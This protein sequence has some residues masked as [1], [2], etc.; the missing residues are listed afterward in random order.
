VEVCNCYFLNSGDESIRFDTS[1]SNNLNNIRIL[2]CQ[3]NGENSTNAAYGI[4]IGLTT[5]ANGIINVQ[6]IGNQV[7]NWHGSGIAVGPGSGSDSS[8]II[9]GNVINNN[10]TGNF[11]AEAGI[12]L[13]T[14]VGVLI[15]GNYLENNQAFGIYL[16]SGDS[17][18]TIVGNDFFNNPVAFGTT[19]S[20]TGV[21][22][23]NNGVD[24]VIVSIPSATNLTV[25]I[26]PNFVITGNTPIT[27]LIGSNLV[28]GAT[29]TFRTPSASIAIGGSSSIGNPITTTINVFV[30]WLWDGSQFWLK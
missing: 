17:D 29:G 14:V 4:D 7:T 5:N 21:F 19:G 23:N 28:P 25:P 12:H 15:V 13:K 1:T 22:K 24:N 10:N 27:Q 8:I 30:S 20:M 11:A 3:I 6:V 9:S 18:V 16:D 26:N 2:G